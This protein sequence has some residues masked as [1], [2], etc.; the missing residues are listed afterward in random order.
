L[1]PDA[2]V[3]YDKWHQRIHPDD[4][5]RVDIAVA[6]CTDPAGDGIY[7]IEYRV[8]G[9][10]GVERWIATR[11]RSSFSDGRAVNLVGVARDITAK[12][13][14]EA[15][16]HESKTRLSAILR[17]LP[18][19]VGL[20]DK[21]GH[22]LLRG[23]LLGSM[24]STAMP[25]SDPSQ[26]GRWR[27]YSGNGNALKP[28]D[29]PE[30]R[31]LRGETLAQGVDFIHTADDGRE[32]WIR[33][34]A[35]PFRNARGE[36]DGAV[37]ILQDIDTEKRA[38][39]AMRESEIRFRQFA[40]HSTDVL[41]ILN[42]ATRHFDDV[43]PA[44]EIVF[45]RP[46]PAMVGYW[47]EAIHP[48]DRDHAL[49]ELDRAAQ[50]ELVVQEYRIL[51]LD[52][53]LRRLRETMFPI[54]DQSGQVKRIGGISQ[55]I[56]SH[57]TSQLYLIGGSARS[58]RVSAFLQRAGYSVR[59]FDSGA[60]FLEMAPVLAP[61]CVVFDVIE[62]KDEVIQTLR[63]FKANRSDLPVIVLGNSRGDV[64][65][66]V[67][68]MKAG[69]VDWL[70]LPD[71]GDEMLAAIAS[72]L[73]EVGR[74]TE[75]K[76]DTDIARASIAGMSER[77]RQVLEFL[78]AGGTNKQIARQLGL[79]PRTVEL[80]RASVMKQLGVKTLSEAVLMATAA[81]VRPASSWRHLKRSR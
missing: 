30:V 56:T 26:G 40:E 63:R 41:W 37:V 46:R 79:S 67:A 39:Q 49:A 2:P 8:N 19:G 28:E 61:G 55:A 1:P 74:A 75:V 57:V 25:S 66:A 47:T 42:V 76:V 10:D 11:G 36:I 16:V 12:K 80:H 17:Q 53:T 18:V 44:Y 60:E 69:A 4:V 24:W 7:E 20:V 70:E 65:Q 33:I 38:E 14:A 54:R 35:A 59:S 32:T 51:H 27:S 21:Q 73:A 71:E 72:A 48:E 34:D 3:D 31:A 62:S 29:Y 52:G 5:A 58:G 22:F 23:G 68:A 78:L 50:G 77:G 64:I 9:A 81:G 6:A 43:S 45:G 15:R 13:A